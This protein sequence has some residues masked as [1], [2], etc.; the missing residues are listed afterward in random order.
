MYKYI[1]AFTNN[2]IKGQALLSI[3]PYELNELGMQ[4]I[5]HQEIVLEGVEQLRN[6]NYNMQQENLQ[7]LALQ[8]ASTATNLHKLLYYFNK[9]SI[10]TQILNDI[11]HT[12][13]TIKPLVFWLNRSPFQGIVTNALLSQFDAALTES[14]SSRMFFP[15]FCSGHLQFNEIR[16]RILQLGIE[17][18]ASAQR[19]RFVENPADQVWHECLVNDVRKN[20]FV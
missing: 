1:N 12:I 8:V 7:F 16:M 3:R 18:A 4:K 9:S 19:D 10:E 17:M 14:K 15:H 11:T 6:F 20:K 13:A 2:E 5:G